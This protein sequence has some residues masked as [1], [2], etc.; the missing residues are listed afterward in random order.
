MT[1][2]K[3]AQQRNIYRYYPYESRLDPK[4]NDKREQIFAVQGN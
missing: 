3:I 1:I 2:D 4:K